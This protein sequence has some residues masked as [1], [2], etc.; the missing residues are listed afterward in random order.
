M[1][2][3][4]GCL[5]L[6]LFAL[7]SIPGVAWASESERLDSIH[8]NTAYLDFGIV[9]RRGV[10][11][12][13]HTDRPNGSGELSNGENERAIYELTYDRDAALSASRDNARA[14]MLAAAV[15][16]ERKRDWQGAVRTYRRL[17]D[18]QGWNGG[19]RD[20]VEVLNRFTRL[21]RR[22]RERLQPV[23][24]RY[25]HAMA[26]V[27]MAA[28]DTNA[29]R[30]FREMAT[31][32]GI[33][34]LGEHC[35]YQAACCAYFHKQYADAIAGFRQQL[36]RYPA[37]DCSDAAL[38]MIARA[39]ILPARTSAEAES[40]ISAVRKLLTRYPRSRFVR[41]AIGLA[42]R[43]HLL[44]GHLHQAAWCYIQVSDLDSAEHVRQAMPAPEAGP[45]RVDL[46][47]GNLLRLEAAHTLYRYTAAI[48][49]LDRLTVRLT[50]ADAFRIS[51]QV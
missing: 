37:G 17:A 48:H 14:R 24:Q 15:E 30:A 51:V 35:E 2:R 16:F 29:E 19:V 9:P 22:T 18:A 39:S 3:Y 6:I 8:F 31:Q 50:A 46:F 1:R 33:G 45:L 21:P 11:W 40:G 20:R 47:T 26:L 43:Y 5:V 28:G 10:M 34:F 23:L 25:L 27:D 7:A 36:S 12:Y 44:A 41:A 32:P 42:G 13:E 38:I 4:R 49:A